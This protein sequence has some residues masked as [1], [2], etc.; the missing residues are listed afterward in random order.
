MKEPRVEKLVEELKTTVE[1][2][3]R[4]NSILV[5]SGTSFHLMRKIT[6]GDFILSEIEQRVEY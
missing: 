2:L 4:I 6:D 5:K 3:N 1:R